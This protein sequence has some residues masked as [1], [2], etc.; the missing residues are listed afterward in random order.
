MAPAT[1][2]NGEMEHV[3]VI[4]YPEGD[5]YIAQCLEFDIATQAKDIPSLLERLD[6]TIDAECAMSREMNE[7]PFKRIAPAPNYFH[8]LWEK[9]SVTLQHL[10]IPV[11]QHLRVEI[12]LAQAA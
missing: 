4:V 2:G 9:R 5:T 10:H 7:E 6:M 1:A 11:Q 8:D 12:A 3:R